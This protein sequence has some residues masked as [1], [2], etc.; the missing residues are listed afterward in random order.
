LKTIDDV[1][2]RAHMGG[3]RGTKPKGR[4]PDRTVLRRCQTVFHRHPLVEGRVE[5]GQFLGQI[6]TGSGKKQYLE[7]ACTRV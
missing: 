1:E 4:H 6:K 5:R 7:Q 2:E 3:G